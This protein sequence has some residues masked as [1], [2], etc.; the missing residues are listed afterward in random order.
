[1]DDE[2]RSRRG[3]LEIAWQA[4]V[5]E[6]TG[7]HARPVVAD[8]WQR[9][10][11][12][13]APELAAAPVAPPEEIARR[14]AASRLGRASRAILDDLTD[15]ASGGDMMAAITDEDVT[16]AWLAG[17]RT[18]S[19]LAERVHFTVGGRW[20]EDAVGTNALAV[21][22]RTRRAS[23]VFSAEHY[24][25][26]VH[27]WV[28]YSAP[29]LDPSTGR[30][31]GVIDLST[32]WHQAHP[33]LLTTVGALARCVEYELTV[34]APTASAV[35]LLG[36]PAASAVWDPPVVDGVLLRTLG[37][38]GVCV[39]GQL[40]PASPRQL[41]LLAV[42]SLHPAGLTLDELA[43]RVYGDRE[44]RPSTVKAELSHLRHQL[45]GR[46]GSRPYRLVGPVFAD[47][48]L[49]LDAV[50]AGDLATAVQLYR[51]PM[52]PASESPDV[53]A[54]RHHVDV[55]VRDAVLRSGQP[56]LLWELSGRCTHDVA[57]HE[58]ALEALAA[59][60]GRRSIVAGRIAGATED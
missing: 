44:V 18:M 40:V 13:V 53:V 39:D 32:V 7:S 5:V 20:S 45:G 21:A 54:W 1:M 34:S 58:A 56:E 6:H 59:T 15:L 17:G 41:E 52:L 11:R 35:P 43:G 51:G 9:S 30:F 29:I 28:C 4:G 14:W 26:M 47:H 42:L 3:E 33:T 55:A 57:V 8:S 10:A 37:T 36:P 60:D 49:V 2:L 25:S 48:H 16:I 27:D 22:E 46:I 31:L 38:T 23:S 24:A 19:R 50:A 12:T